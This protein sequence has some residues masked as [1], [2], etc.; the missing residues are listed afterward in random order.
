MGNTTTTNNKKKK[1]NARKLIPAIGMLMTSAAMLTT[2]TYAWFTMNK[3]VSITGIT[4]TATVPETL[5]I[6]LGKAGGLAVNGFNYVPE[7]PLNDDDD[8]YN[9]ETNKDWTN[10]ISISDYYKDSS[11]NVLSFGTLVPVSSQNGAK[12]FFT[13][14]AIG[15]GHLLSDEAQFLEVSTEFKDSSKGERYYLDIPVWFRTTKQNTS[16]N[17]LDIDMVDLY[18]T[19][20]ISA[21]ENST[22]VLYKAARVSVLKDDKSANKGVLMNSEAK[23]YDNGEE[24]FSVG[25]VSEIDANNKAVKTEVD[26]NSPNE[27]VVQVPTRTSS[28]TNVLHGGKVERIIRIWLEGEDEACY[29]PNA[30]QSFKINLTFSQNQPS[31]NNGG[32]QQGQ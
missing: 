26:V 31:S 4:L 17:N 7:A 3:E 11:N 9:K 32:Q 29:N 18:V 30:G 28:D 22:D 25:P 14:D 20:T 24:G 15:D 1:S 8:E 12:M 23:Y 6:S 21:P 5:E 10:S 19:A 13:D 27:A 2:S 16:D